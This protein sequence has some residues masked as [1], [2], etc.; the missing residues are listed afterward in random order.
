MDKKIIRRKLFLFIF[1]CFLGNLFHSCIKENNNTIEREF[2]LPD[3]CECIEI[4]K[5]DSI[6][7]NTRYVFRDIYDNHPIIFCNNY[8]TPLFDSLSTPIPL[9]YNYNIT[10]I[11]WDKEYCYFSSD[12]T[13]FID[14]GGNIYPIIVSNNKIEFFS[15]SENSIL[16]ASDSSL[17]SFMPCTNEINELVRVPFIIKYIKQI[18]PC[19]FLSAGKEIY[20]IYENNLYHIFSSEEEILCFD[21]DS[22]GGIFI[23]TNLGLSYL[24]VDYSMTNVVNIPTRNMTIIDDDLYVIFE[25]GSSVMITNIHN[26][27]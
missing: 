21:V 27:K 12:S 5:A 3:A 18:P 15:V 25:D 14:K 24:N 7:L 23:G 9:P 17:V 13:L 22:S 20:L 8:I 1:F 6:P 10:D 19:I 4:L 2:L 16:F 26:F 11:H